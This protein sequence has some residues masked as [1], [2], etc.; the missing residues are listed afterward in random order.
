MIMRNLGAE[1]F[2]CVAYNLERGSLG[3]RIIGP[4]QLEGGGCTFY[5][6]TEIVVVH[7]RPK[8]AIAEPN[9]TSA[10]TKTPSTEYIIH[11]DQS[12]LCVPIQSS[13]R[14]PAL[15]YNDH[16]ESHL[17]K[18]SITMNHLTQASRLG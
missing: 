13:T 10:V 15:E 9:F 11:T 16:L 18:C 12:I 4:Y 3:Q 8:F 14:I 17:I 5:F 6:A 7:D 1:Y 2:L